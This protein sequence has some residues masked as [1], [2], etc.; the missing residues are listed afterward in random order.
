MMPMDIDIAGKNP[1]TFPVLH[2]WGWEIAL[3][4]F[5]GGLAAGLLVLAGW[6]H[7]RAHSSPPGPALG[8]MAPVL[9][10]AVLGVGMFALFLDL[11]NRLNVWRFYTA[12]RLTAPM[13]W[14]AWILVLVFPAA[15]LFAWAAWSEF[16]PP[17]RRWV[18]GAPFPLRRWIAGL[19]IVLGVAL[20]V[21]TGILLGALGARPLWNSPL[22]GPLFLASG[23]SAAAALL[24]LLEK[25][26]QWR[27]RLAALDLRF[28]AAE[29]LLLALF[30]L[31]LATGGHAQRAAAGLF[32][33]GPYTA[34]FWV[35]VA[36]AGIALPAWLERLERRRR[37]AHSAVA[38]VLVL[39]GGL[40]LRAVILLAGQ[41][42]HWE[43]LL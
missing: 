9:A 13:S 14:G 8:W 37:I 15:L 25:D 17:G 40:A 38:P 36:F 21:Y 35:M 11:E 28:L 18:T 16:G 43:V 24:V 12:F 3:Y 26:G 6:A 39:F 34:V 22:L 27:D 10:P 33:G 2:V 42:S 32:F 41:A 4:L 30:F 23:L 20:G 1:E 5:L 29:A 31:A 7:R 19:N